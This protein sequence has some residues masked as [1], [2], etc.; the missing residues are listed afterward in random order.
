[1]ADRPRLEELDWQQTPMGELML[2]RRVELVTDEEVY[3]VRLG[4]EYLMSS[5]FTVAERALARVGL[6]H[7][8]PGDLDVLV[9]GLGLGYTAA[10]ALRE[11]RVAQLVVVEALGP[12]ID[13]HA[14]RLLPVSDAVAGDPRCRMVEGD[15]FALVRTGALGE[16]NETRSGFDAILLDVDHTPTHHLDPSHSDFYTAAGLERLSAALRPGGVFGLWSDESAGDEFLELLLS[17]FGSAEEHDV[18]FENPITRGTSSNTV[19]LA[20]TART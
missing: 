17:V 18:P 15:F 12:V 20:R 5:A 11:P 7:A 2:R 19:Y 9:G 16:L 4:D 6:E 8:H 1:M 10:E 14:R 13:W 3:E